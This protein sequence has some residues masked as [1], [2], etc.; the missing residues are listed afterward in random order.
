MA[1]RRPRSGSVEALQWFA[2]APRWLHG[3]SAV[4]PLLSRLV[5]WR[6]H[7]DS[8]V[9]KHWYRCSASAERGGSKAPPRWLQLLL[10]N[11]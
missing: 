8:A 7:V 3:D 6:L 11:P 2:A 4:A 9:A 1:S 10:E 5:L